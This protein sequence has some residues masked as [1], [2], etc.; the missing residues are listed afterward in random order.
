[1]SGYYALILYIYMTVP[2]YSLVENVSCFSVA[3]I[4]PFAYRSDGPAERSGI[5][6]DEYKSQIIFGL[7]ARVKQRLWFTNL[8]VYHS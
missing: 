2:M 7:Q 6:M 1:M 5:C 4:S 8:S 3:H